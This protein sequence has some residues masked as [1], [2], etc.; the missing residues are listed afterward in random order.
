M[1]RISLALIIILSL[2]TLNLVGCNTAAEEMSIDKYSWEL[3]SV[4]SGPQ[5]NIIAYN[6]ENDSYASSYPDAS[7]VNM[8]LTAGDGDF[9]LTD[10]TNGKTYEGTYKV[11]EDKQA[12]VIY[13]INL[14]EHSGYAGVA[15]TSFHD[16]SQVPTLNISIDDY[17]LNFHAPAVSY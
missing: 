13:E 2:L 6:A 1:K 16:G 7:P 3:T 4:Q 12:N 14:D 5:G 10:T 8:Y 15:M 11:I 17:A 9:V